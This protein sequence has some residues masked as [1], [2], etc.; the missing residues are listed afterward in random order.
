MGGWPVASGLSNWIFSYWKPSLSDA[1]NYVADAQSFRSAVAWSCFLGYVFTFIA[2]GFLP[3]LPDQ[4]DQT[5]LRLATYPRH[6]TFALT[7][8]LVLITALAY[9]LTVDFLSIIP[10]TSCLV[11]AGGP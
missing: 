8:L 6:W 1:N 4:K 9:S 2:L 7:T 3:L 10:S 5:Q 11:I